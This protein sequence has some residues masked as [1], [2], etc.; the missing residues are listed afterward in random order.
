MQDKIEQLSKIKKML[1]DGLVSEEEFN[2]L[3]HGILSDLSNNGT[4]NRVYKNVYPE[5]V[6]RTIKGKYPNLFR[7]LFILAILLIAGYSFYLLW[8]KKSMAQ[9][10]S[11]AN[12]NILVSVDTSTSKK[13]Y[14]ENVSPTAQSVTPGRFP[15]ASERFLTSNDVINLNKYQ[16][17]IMRNEIFAR[18]G[19]I[20]KTPEMKSYFSQQTWYHG[21][22]DNVNS[23]LSD[24]EKRNIDLI[25]MY[26]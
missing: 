22:Y 3:K 12:K 2:L 20:F 4:Q 21:Q 10:P 6:K 15:Q 25:K 1:D 18:H 19:Y 7:T 13:T 17:K 23:M 16:L 26:E 9:E 5:N 8:E 11:V 24:I 14:Q